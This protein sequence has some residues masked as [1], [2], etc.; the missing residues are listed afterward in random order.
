MALRVASVSKKLNRV[1][2]ARMST[3]ER[4]AS[5]LAPYTTSAFQVVVTGNEFFAQTVLG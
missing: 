1:R 4:A 5:S 3:V 2:R